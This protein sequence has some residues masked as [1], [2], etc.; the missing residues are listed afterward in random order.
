MC[1][2]N[3][4]TYFIIPCKHRTPLVHDNVLYKVLL[5]CDMY[6]CLILV[7]WQM[8][9]DKVLYCILSCSSY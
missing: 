6:L 8:L 4:G 9:N 5:D 2:H 7:Y 3:Y 1:N